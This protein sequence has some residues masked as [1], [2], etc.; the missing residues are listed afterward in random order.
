MQEPLTKSVRISEKAHSEL[1]R[2]CLAVF[3]TTNI[4]YSDAIEQFCERI[5]AEELEDD[6]D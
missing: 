1:E 2:A 6:N 4:R 5:I 3:G